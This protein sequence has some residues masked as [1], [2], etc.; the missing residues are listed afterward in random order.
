VKNLDIKVVE[1]VNVILPTTMNSVYQSLDVIGQFVV[2][3]SAIFGFIIF[4]LNLICMIKIVQ[5]RGFCLTTTAN[6]IIVASLCGSNIL[7]GLTSIAKEVLFVFVNKNL[8]KFWKHF[9]WYIVIFCLISSSLHIILICCTYLVNTFKSHP[10]LI[11]TRGRIIDTVLV[12]IIWVL[13]LLPASIPTDDKD[14]RQFLNMVSFMLLACTFSL[15]P[16]LVMILR[17]GQKSK[18]TL[19]SSSEQFNFKSNL[20]KTR[21]LRYRQKEKTTCLALMASYMMCSVPYMLYYPVLS[22]MYTFDYKPDLI[23]DILFLFILGKCICDSIIY[24]IRRGW[25]KPQRKVNFRLKEQD[26]SPV[27]QVNE[28][29]AV[30]VETMVM[31]QRNDRETLITSD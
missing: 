7:V 11:G 20:V 5:Q 31:T 24:I 12:A 9:E 29:T 26:S 15:L 19:Q 16:I 3:G 14:Y 1:T 18:K 21:W 27:K 4:V 28:T 25:K 13:S 2:L 6:Q 23:D 30:G 17:C 8:P 10:R 22:K